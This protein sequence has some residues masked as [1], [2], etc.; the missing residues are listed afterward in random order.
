MTRRRAVAVAAAMGAISCGALLAPRQEA[1]AQRIDPRRANSFVVGAPGGP[2]PALRVDAARSGLTHDVLPTGALH[3]GWRKTF[4]LAVEQPALAGADGTLALVTSR[5]DVVFLD[6][7]G[8]EVGHVTAATTS[9]GPAAITSD[10]T[11]VF[12]TA[13]GD[14]IGVRRQMASRRFLTHVGGERNQRTAPLPLDDGGVVVATMTDLIVLDAEGNVRTRTTLPAPSAAPLVATGDKILAITTTGA[15]YGWTPGREPVRLGSFGAP[16]DGGAALSDANTLVAVIE[17]NHVVEL[18]LSTGARATRA[19]S[20]QGLYLGPPSVR[21]QTNGNLVTLL[22]M[23][24]TRSAVVTLDPAGQEVLRAAV[25]SVTATTLPDGGV[26]PL[27]APAHVG[28]LVDPRGAVA[29]AAPDGHVGLVA[30][31]G[32]SETIGELLCTK[33]SR[34]SGVAGLTPFGPGSFAVTC[35]GGAVVRIDGADVAPRPR[36][37]VVPATSARPH[38]P[39]KA[40]MPPDRQPLPPPQEDDEPED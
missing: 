17:T 3:V 14:A 27:V 32:S 8:E 12:V 23:T 38:P 29:F 21:R 6:A 31:D 20:S 22:A 28:P 25:G 24:P 33:T 9:V 7:D 2:S 36:R 10:G 13:S 19:I 18:N 4:G 15:V 1:A 30:A 11:V 37:A 35:E 16:I 40:P 39:P 5:G 34:S 26:A